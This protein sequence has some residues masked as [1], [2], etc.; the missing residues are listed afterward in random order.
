MK[1]IK[2]SVGLLAALI[3]C[4]GLLSCSQDNEAASQDYAKLADEDWETLEK[5][6][7]SIQYPPD[8]ELDQS[9]QF[10]AKFFLISPMESG[11][12]TFKENVSLV[13]EATPAGMS[14][15]DYITASEKGLRQ[16]LSN[17]KK[18]EGRKIEDNSG[19]H[20]EL[21]STFDQGEIHVKSRQ[22]FWI[23]HGKAYIL[24]LSCTPDSYDKYQDV[25]KKILRSFRMK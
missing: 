18:I 8:W 22:H 19:E 21:I 5:P 13:T 15:D 17:Y 10:G 23:F 3:L 12:D 9:G 4:G 11:N 16:L 2:T 7:Y 20:Y 25:G 6:D 14:L 1:F 24:T